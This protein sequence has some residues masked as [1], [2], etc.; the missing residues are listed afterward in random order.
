MNGNSKNINE[1]CANGVDNV[2][3]KAMMKESLDNLS[4]VMIAFKNL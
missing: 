3:R 2:L 1:I 4:V